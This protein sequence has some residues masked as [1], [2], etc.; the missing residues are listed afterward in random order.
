MKAKDF[1]DKPID[2]SIYIKDMARELAKFTKALENMGQ[3]QGKDMAAALELLLIAV[4]KMKLDL[5]APNVSVAVPEVRFAKKW[6]FRVD[7]GREGFINEVIAE[8]I[9]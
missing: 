5:P 8:K 6:R 9:E 4:E 1:L 3:S 7:R 2:S